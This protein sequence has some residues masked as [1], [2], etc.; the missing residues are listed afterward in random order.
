MTDEEFNKHVEALINKKEQ[1]MKNLREERNY[2]WNRIASGYYDFDRYSKDVEFLK[3]FKKSDAI[4]YYSENVLNSSNNGKLVVHLQ[5]QKPPVLNKIKM[6]KNSILNFIYD[7]DEF[8][9]VEYESDKV[10]EKID[11]FFADQ[12]N[13]TEETLKEFFTDKLFESFPYKQE[14]IIEILSNI[15]KDWNSYDVNDG[16]LVDV[17]GEWKCSVPLT[18]APTA[19]I[20]DKHCDKEIVL[21]KF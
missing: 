13:I 12:K 14:V 6:I 3:S 16:T 2:Y 19:K 7:K 11:A 4:N 20:E 15:A 17:V 9:D 21:G 5:S 10:N 18:V 1:K 8:D